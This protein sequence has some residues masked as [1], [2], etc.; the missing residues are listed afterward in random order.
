MKINSKS[1]QQVERPS[2]RAGSENEKHRRVEEPT[3]QTDIYIIRNSVSPPEQEPREDLWEFPIIQQLW[4]NQII[5]D[6]T[7]GVS[8]GRITEA[9][10]SIEVI[11]G[12][13]KIMRRRTY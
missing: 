3:E 1:Q 5:M 2:S 9:K 12:D 4:H 13:M 10:H 8:C 6:D 7:T 11:R